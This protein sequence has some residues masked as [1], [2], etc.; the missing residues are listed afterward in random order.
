MV[1]RER[2]RKGEGWSRKSRRERA[3]VPPS[4]FSSLV[5]LLHFLGYRELGRFEGKR[6]TDRK[7]N[8]MKSQTLHLEQQREEGY[9]QTH[10]N[11]S[12]SYSINKT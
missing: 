5:C 11:I 12:K 7:K 8:L 3:I 9:R 4:L 10:V 2:R 6:E 1:K